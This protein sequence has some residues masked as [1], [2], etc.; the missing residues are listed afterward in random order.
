MLIPFVICILWLRVGVS[1][2]FL[3]SN[4]SCA[5]LSF[6]CV[7]DSVLHIPYY[8]QRCIPEQAAPFIYDLLDD[9]EIA[10]TPS[11]R[12]SIQYQYNTFHR[13]R[14]TCPHVLFLHCSSSLLQPSHS[15]FVLPLDSSSPVTLSLLSSSHVPHAALV[16]R[17]C[18]SSPLPTTTHS[19]ASR[20][21]RHPP[22][23]SPLSSSSWPFSFS[24]AAPS[25]LLLS[26]F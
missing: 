21:R 13:G 25:S 11:S 19:I 3:E 9:T 7:K 16:D 18:V 26:P 22:A 20:C 14:S 2:L 5:T 23:S 10:L 8:L 4:P 24:S 12:L 1:L 15:S 6:L 17:R